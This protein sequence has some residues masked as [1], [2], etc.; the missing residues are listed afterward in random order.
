MRYFHDGLTVGYTSRLIL[1]RDWL[2]RVFWLILW[3]NCH[4]IAHIC[5]YARIVFAFVKGWNRLAIDNIF[6]V[7]SHVKDSTIEHAFTFGDLVC[8][9]F[10]T[11]LTVGHAFTLF[12]WSG[13]TECKH[14][15]EP[16]NVHASI[17]N[18]IICRTYEG[19]MLTQHNSII[20]S[21]TI[22]P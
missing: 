19:R 2:C 22:T 21:E 9:T 12:L 15:W 16:R 14:L 7:V 11:G 13:C 4:S 5:N 10:V 17:H 1:W 8:I 20:S 6:E 3:R 18:C